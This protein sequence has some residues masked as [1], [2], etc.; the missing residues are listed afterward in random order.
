M[1]DAGS[2]PAGLPF[3]P[4]LWPQWPR[5][6]AEMPSPELVER[7]AGLRAAGDWRAAAALLPAT[8]DID[9]A[10]VRERFG[11]EAAAALEDDLRHLCLDLLWWHLPRHQGGRTTLQARVSAVLAP[12]SGAG[13]A[14]LLCVRLPRSPTGAQR[15]R[16]GV[17]GLSDLEYERW[18]LAP[19]Y[20]W[21]VR[22][23]DRLHAMWMQPRV[24]SLLSAGDFESAWREC[25]IA[26]NPDALGNLQGKGAPTNPVGVADLAREAAA[27]FGVT[28]VS[29]ILGANLKL[30]VPADG[31]VT[32]EPFDPGEWLE[33]PVRIPTSSVPPELALLTAGLL[34]PSELHP[35][36]RAALFPEAAP[37]RGAPPPEP[38]RNIGYF[39]AKCHGEW[40]RMSIQSGA[41][42]LHDHD[43]VEHTREAALRALGGASS[44]CFAIEE[45][46]HRGR[47]RLPR[48]LHEHRRAVI[49]RLQHGDTEYL[50]AGLADGT[51]DPLMRAG[52][53]W[54]L[55]HMAMWLD[56]ERVLPA[57]LAAGVPVDARDNVDRTPLYVGVM[58]GADPELL[59]LLCEAG[60]DPRAETVHGVSA[61]A[62]ARNYADDRDLRFMNGR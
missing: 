13:T 45:F 55:L 61:A 39:R 35:L 9:L 60:A 17:V 16:L 29:T 27:A 40:H 12:R 31:P 15:V 42:Q 8:V 21:D 48:A 51:I 50:L 7:A 53:G 5:V 38:P 18:Y 56:Y 58:N 6:R 33:V 32:A 59:R 57:L 24:Y 10:A 1:E 4:S 3:P 49:H 11:A 43:E 22:A 62:V 52:N 2:I 54:S 14:P 25:G 46:W 30:T 23:T 20:T 19:R 37:T 44:G 26:L 34:T 47:G 36:I 28:E 41:L